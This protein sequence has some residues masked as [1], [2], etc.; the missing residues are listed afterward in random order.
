MYHIN[1]LVSSIFTV[2]HLQYMSPWRKNIV[3]GAKTVGE[4]S[5]FYSQ[6]SFPV[7][8]KIFLNVLP[9]GPSLPVIFSK[10]NKFLLGSYQFSCKLYLYSILCTCPV[11]FAER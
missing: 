9:A 6:I 10:L 4:F 8:C 2:S 5:R 1:S 7:C 3:T 11:P